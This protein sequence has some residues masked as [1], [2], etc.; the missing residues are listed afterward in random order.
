MNKY[1]VL[2]I[3]VDS[4]RRYH[5]TGDDRSRLDIMDEFGKESVEFLNVVTS[6]PST[7]MAIGAMMSGMHSYYINRNFAD[8][9]YD[10]VAFPSL[11]SI[12]RD[13]GYHNYN[14]WMSRESRETMRNILPIIGH[15]YWPSGFK[16]RHWW[17]NSQINLLVDKSLSMGVENPAFFFVDYN[18]RRDRQTSDKVKWAIEKLKQAGYTKDN[19]ITILCSDHGYP[20]PSKET[21]RP[22]FYKKHGIGHD[23]VLTDDNIMIPLLIQYPGCA[24]GKKIETTVGGIDIF[25][26]IL[27]VLRMDI[28]SGVHGKSLIPLIDGEPEYKEMMESRFHRCDSRLSC[29]TG[30]GTA[31]R[32]NRYKYVYYHDDTRG[33]NE[34]FFDIVNDELETNDLIDSED[35]NIKKQLDVF[36]KE[37]QESEKGA[38]NFQLNYLFQKFSTEHNNEIQEA[39]EILITD[40]CS[41][42]FIDMLVRMIR[43]INSQA[44]VNVLFVEHEP[45]SVKEDVAAICP[46][47]SSWSEFKAATVREI[48]GSTKFDVLFAPYN[49]SEQR[50]N[51]KFTAIVRRIKAKNKVYLDYN[52]GSFK[53]TITY[54]WKN[55]KATWPFMKYEP[56]FLLSSVIFQIRG[57]GRITWKKLTGHFFKKD[58]NWSEVLKK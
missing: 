47:A 14:Y 49:T 57:L 43:R 24:E 11:P 50:D 26:T 19:T 48:F 23:L 25:P 52:M 5:S 40:S 54:Y 35:E 38:T 51:A 58:I 9:M 31:I 13:N 10:E 4:V 27:D 21:G 12:L 7:Y 53:K 22:D 3:F 20:D 44:K 2:C 41:P 28:P 34:E 1:N 36:R 18:C 6:A 37:F 42:L 8:F 15:K 55:F 46:D 56:L 30:R 17:S 39:K 32:N 16:H 45:E 33:K 29:Q